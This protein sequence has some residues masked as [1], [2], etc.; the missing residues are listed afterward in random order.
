MPFDIKRFDGSVG[1]GV[2]SGPLY[3]KNRAL[4]NSFAPTI[5]IP[6]RG[7]IPTVYPVFLRYGRD[8]ERGGI[9]WTLRSL[10]QDE[11]NPIRL[12]AGHG[13]L[14]VD[15]QGLKADLETFFAAEA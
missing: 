4:P 9:A 2:V 8:N 15:S 14:R 10:I 6:D 1:M 3:P 7:Q 13:T 11:N 12:V 5:T